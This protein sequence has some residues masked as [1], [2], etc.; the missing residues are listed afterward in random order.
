MISRNWAAPPTEGVYIRTVLLMFRPRSRTFLALL[1]ALAPTLYGPVA[2]AAA[3]PTP[4]EISVARRLFDEG[5][6]AEEAGRFAEAAAKFRRAIAIKDTPGMRYHLAHCEEEQGAFV[7][8]LVEYDRA[9]ELIDNGAKAA[10]VAKLLDGARE[11]VRAKVAL[12]TLLLPKDLK[13]V[14]VMLDGKPLSPSVLELPLPINPGKHRVSVAAAGRTSF[15]HDLELGLG[16]VKQ[17]AI[18][19]PVTTTAVAPAAPVPPPTATNRESAPAPA[20]N[21]GSGTPARTF[22][23]AAEASLFAAALTTGIVFTIAKSGADDRY[24]TAN[25]VVLSGGDDPLGTAC[26]MTPPRQGC[27][28]LESARCDRIRDRTWATVGFVTAGV[29]AAAFGLTLG[30]W[31]TAPAR[32]QASAA[33][34]RLALSVSGRF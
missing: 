29:S 4:S 27:A 20:R 24:Q 34:G 11:K 1:L 15:E 12:L 33:P 3:E 13:N 18:E 30:F 5:K 25:E 2:S 6:A 14:A 16:E 31:R 7:E 23:L 10:D 26:S 8:A 9:R 19:L 17:L 21:S 22:V 32:V 28:D